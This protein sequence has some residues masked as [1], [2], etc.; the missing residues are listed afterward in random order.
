MNLSFA[1]YLR[2]MYHDDKD[3]AG[4]QLQF[5]RDDNPT[6]ELIVSVVSIYVKYGVEYGVQ[7]SRYQ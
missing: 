6:G 2:S 3:I 1:V 4:V 7:D 5:E